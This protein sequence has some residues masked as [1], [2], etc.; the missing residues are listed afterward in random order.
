M[1]GRIV[2]AAPPKHHCRPGVTEATTYLKLPSRWSHPPGTVWEC[3]CGRSY[4][5]YRPPGADQSGQIGRIW[6][7]RESKLRR[8]RRLRK[9]RIGRRDIPADQER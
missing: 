8:W 5:A 9:T 1:T 2:Q 4:V 7:H 3:D 6:W